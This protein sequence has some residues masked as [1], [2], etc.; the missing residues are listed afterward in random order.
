MKFLRIK[1]FVAAFVMFTCTS[2]F[3]SFSYDFNI[4]TASVAGQ[5]GYIELQFNPLN[6]TW[7]DSSWGAASAM[8]TNWASD[9]VLRSSTVTGAVT[10]SFPAVTINNTSQLNRYFQLVTFGN[11]AKFSLNLTSADADE[12]RL[13]FWDTNRITPL[14]TTD[15]T[16]GAATIIDVFTMN[17][18]IVLNLSNQVTVS[19]V[20]LPGAIWL[21]GSGLVGLIGLKRKFLG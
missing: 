11:F 14:L 12:F 21:F 15:Q 7:G 19:P 5:T 10:G 17:A 4:N 3:A 20:P 13:S 2:A 16:Y 1:I 9:A 6:P 18:N 8:I